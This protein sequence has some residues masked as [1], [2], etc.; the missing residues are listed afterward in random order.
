[1]RLLASERLQD[2][3]CKIGPTGNAVSGTQYQARAR[4]LG[5]RFKDFTRLFRGECGIPLQESRGVSERDVHC[6]H[7][8]RSAVQLNIQT[9]PAIVMSL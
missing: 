1:M 4:V 5:Y 9:I 7:G 3:E 8:L 6:P 2:F